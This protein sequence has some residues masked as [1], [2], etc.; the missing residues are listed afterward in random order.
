MTDSFVIKNGIL[1]S[2]LGNNTT[3]I[4]PSIVTRIGKRAFANSSIRTV[5]FEGN[6]LKSID[7]EAFFKCSNLEYILIPDGVIQIGD[8]AF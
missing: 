6:G 5:S 4:I 3:V 7:E 8:R 1:E 2:Y